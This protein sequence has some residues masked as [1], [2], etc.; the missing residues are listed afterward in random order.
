M[1]SRD[2]FFNILAEGGLDSNDSKKFI[3]IFP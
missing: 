1:S 2:E 3:Q